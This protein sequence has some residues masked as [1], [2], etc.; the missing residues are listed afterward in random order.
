MVVAFTR[1]GSWTPK[2]SLI[3]KTS[4]DKTTEG[5]LVISNGKIRRKV[6]GKQCN[7]LLG[8]LPNGSLKY[9]ENDSYKTVINDGVKNTF[10]FGPLLIKDGKSYTQK[11]GSPRQSYSGSAAKRTA[12]GQIDE[13]NFV[14]ITT[15]S[16][17]KLSEIRNLGLSI[18]C[19]TLYNL[20]GG[21]STTLWFRNAKKGKGT[22]IKS[23]SRGVGDTLYFTSL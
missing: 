14:I 12:I 1:S 21:G 16:T 23:S 2:E 18:G 15:A 10:T 4:W 19:K 22:Q 8:I 11:V 20:D 17:A 5:Y 9:Y 3:K 6:N 13:N 7:A